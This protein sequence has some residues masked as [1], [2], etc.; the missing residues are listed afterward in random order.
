MPEGGFAAPAAEPVVGLVEDV[1]GGDGAHEVPGAF[2]LGA[3]TFAW[4]LE[5]GDQV[6]R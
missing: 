4:G 6:Q 1:V 2:R 5:V 3:R